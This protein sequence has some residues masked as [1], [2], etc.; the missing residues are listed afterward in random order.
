[1]YLLCV[2]IAHEVATFKI[3]VH[4]CLIE[5]NLNDFFQVKGRMLLAAWE[6]G[7]SSVSEE[8]INAVV[9]NTKVLNF[10]FALLFAVFFL[11]VLES[12]ELYFF[13]RW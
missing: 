7:F 10:D 6:A 5:I 8:A 4:Q 1:M 3:F 2:S 11:N 12:D 13:F 9:A